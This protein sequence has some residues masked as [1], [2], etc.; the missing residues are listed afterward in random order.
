M[1]NYNKRLG[2]IIAGVGMWGAALYGALAV[3]QLRGDWGHGVCGP[4]GCGPP[5]QALVSC[6]LFWVVLFVL[7]ACLVSAHRTPASL[8]RIGQGLLSGGA[9]GLLAVAAWQA[10]VW[11]PAVPGWSRSYF[12]ERY[13]FTLATLVEAPIVQT[14]TGRRGALA[15]CD[16]ATRRLGGLLTVPHR[17]VFNRLVKKSLELGGRL[18]AFL[19]CCHFPVGHHDQHRGK[20]PHAELL[21]QFRTLFA[22][23]RQRDERPIDLLDD[24]RISKRFALHQGAIMATG[25][26]HEDDHGSPRSRGELKRFGLV[27]LPFNFGGARA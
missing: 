20:C 22:V 8:R 6:H 5:A 17:A 4:W 21:H 15:D 11:L 9:F 3:S 12:F 23:D 2:A 16:P 27:G 25:G 24:R 19:E 13:L 1:S 10:L 14:G 7:P 18:K 26:R